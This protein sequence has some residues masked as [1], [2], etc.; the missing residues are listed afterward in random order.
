VKAYSTQKK[1]DKERRKAFVEQHGWAKALPTEFWPQTP[2]GG[3][4]QWFPPLAWLT[5]TQAAQLPAPAYWPAIQAAEEADGVSI[6]PAGKKELCSAPP[7][8]P[9]PAP[10]SKILTY[11]RKVKNDDEKKDADRPNED[12]DD[13]GSWWTSSAWGTGNDSRR[14]WKTT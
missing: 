2:D 11:K 9:P 10:A 1:K 6:F 14:S 8:P 4:R 12:D 5:P 7:P 13:W 3:V